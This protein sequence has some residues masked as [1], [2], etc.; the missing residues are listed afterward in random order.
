MLLTPGEQWRWNY[1]AEQDR[2][3]LNI[4]SDLQ[5][6]SPFSGKQLYQLPAEQPLSMAEAEAYWSCYQ[7]LNQ[8]SLTR[9]DCMELALTALAA[10]S[11]L[12]LQAHKSWYF[13]VMPEAAVSLYD[14]VQLSGESHVMALIIQQDTDC[15]SCLLL[16]PVTTLA[17]KTLPRMT[18]IRV[19]NNRVAALSENTLARAS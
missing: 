9:S 4:S 13:A 6:C 10:C 19:L 16:E 12:Q 3:L 18:V 2:L 15:V 8:L 14:V 7:N 5:F 1:C 17:G 11:F